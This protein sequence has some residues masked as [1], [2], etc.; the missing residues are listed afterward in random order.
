MAARATSRRR[1]TLFLA[2]AV[3]AA[4]LPGCITGERPTLASGPMT[5]GDPAV[6]DVLI[7]LDTAPRSTFGGM[8]EVLTRDGDLLTPVTVAQEGSERRSVTIGDIRFLFD[9]SSMATCDLAGGTCSDTIDTDLVSDTR[10]TPDFYATGAAA[11]LRQ[12]AEARTGPTEAAVEDIA[13]YPATCVTVPLEDDSS[14]YCALDS[15]PLARLDASDL[16]ID[17]SSWSGSVDESAFSRPD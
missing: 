16:Q 9:G 6:D 2:A 15:G 5:S 4:A 3:S 13:G 7:R 8:Y 12:D 14:T 1:R 10:L 17:L 11:R